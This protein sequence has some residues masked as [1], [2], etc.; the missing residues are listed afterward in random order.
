MYLLLCHGLVTARPLLAD[1]SNNR[2]VTMVYV[3]DALAWLSCVI[4]IPAQ[5][6]CPHAPSLPRGA[7]HS[8]Y[9]QLYCIFD[10]RGRDLTFV[11]Y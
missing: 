11:I 9:F 5:E 6:A 8:P 7:P 2:R 10:G 4:S 1:V 3:N